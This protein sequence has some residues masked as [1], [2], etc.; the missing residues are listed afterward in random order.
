M[1]GTQD[2]S[3]ISPLRLVFSRVVEP[4]RRLAVDLADHRTQRTRRPGFQRRETKFFDDPVELLRLDSCSAQRSLNIGARYDGIG[5]S[6]F[7]QDI[8][9]ESIKRLFPRPTTLRS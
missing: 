8:N 9:H 3:D 4:A 5:A 1:A 7:I 6:E 2:E